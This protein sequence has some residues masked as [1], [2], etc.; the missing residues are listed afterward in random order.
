MAPDPETARQAVIGCREHVDFCRRSLTIRDKSGQVVPLELT[1]S[2]I[3]LT[4]AIRSQERRGVPVRVVVLKA[5]QIHMSVGCCSHIWKR[6]AFLPGQQAMVFGDL[7]RSAANLWGYL[8]HFTEAYRP[9][10]GLK[11]LPLKRRVRDRR[12]EWEGR[13]WIDVASADSV[14]SGRSYSIRH[15]LLSEYAFYRD[16]GSLMTGI[17]QSVPDDPLTTVLIEST[18]NGIGGGFYDLWQRACDPSSES[19]WVAVF[20]GWHEHP[21]YVREVSD[22]EK[23]EA[24]LTDEEH[25]LRQRFGL[26]L[27]QLAWRRWAIEAKCEGS[28]ERFRQEYPATP[29]EAFVTSGR[30]RFCLVSLGRQQAQRDVPA[31]YLET[32]RV[33][34]REQVQFVPRADGHGPLRIWRK[35]E[36]GREYVIGADTAE[37]IDAGADRGFSDPDYSVAQVLD[38][39]T[40]EQVAV[41]RDR[42]TPSVFGEWLCAL[43]QFYHWAY[44]VPEANGSGIATIE[45]IL[46]RQYPGDRIYSRERLADDRRS[47]RLE[48]IGFRTT[49]VSK[50][51]LV[52]LLDRAILEQAIT[53]YD[54]ITLQECRTFVYKPN[55]RQEAQE[56]CH[57]DCVIALALAVLGIQTAPRRR[58]WDQRP[59]IQ[60]YGRRPEERPHV[61]VRW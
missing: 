6:V 42:V 33:G 30:P 1:P 51:Q 14:T 60:E 16:T 49:S 50:P 2:Q 48:E 31:G 52:S 28:L 35:P 39:D 9:Y 37:G 59:A 4:E 55:G 61:V 17:M 5:R 18:A 46:R 11:Q 13:S 45:E 26:S 43:G 12:L 20:F 15:L 8:D 22:P 27:E 53:I 32:V 19:G 41:F 10:H 58:K 21:E 29:E 24:S 7:Y 34:T 57:D 54:P 36:Q 3:K 47:A 40:G 56:G 23:F 44:L 25:G 38:R